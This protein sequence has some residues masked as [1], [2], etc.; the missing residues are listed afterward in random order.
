[1][2]P[3]CQR[4]EK[5]SKRGRRHG[6]ARGRI[7]GPLGRRA[8]KVRRFPL[9]SSFSETIPIQT[10]PFKIKPKIFQ[11]FSQNFIHF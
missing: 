3:S 4:K 8:R 9:F 7:G 1:V 6:L 2:G 10:F 11:T 5:K